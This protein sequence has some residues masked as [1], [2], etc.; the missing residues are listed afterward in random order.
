MAYLPS[1]TVSLLL[2]FTTVVVTLIGIVLLA[3]RPTTLQWLGV[4]V[5]I[6]SP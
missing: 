5:N 4:L 3:E 2:N 6:P 1:V